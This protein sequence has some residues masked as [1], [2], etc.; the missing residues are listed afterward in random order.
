VNTNNEVRLQKVGE[1]LNEL[2]K[3]GSHLDDVYEALLIYDKYKGMLD[4][5]I[6][7][8]SLEMYQSAIAAMNEQIHNLYNMMNTLSDIV[9]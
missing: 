8:S 5:D 2:V 7:E 4:I 9:N 1:V 3:I 6:Y